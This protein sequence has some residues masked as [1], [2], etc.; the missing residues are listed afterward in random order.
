MLVQI[1]YGENKFKERL[2]K[3]IGYA[4]NASFIH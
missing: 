4:V 3:K 2:I 1:N